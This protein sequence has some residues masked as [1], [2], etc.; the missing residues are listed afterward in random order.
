MKRISVLVLLVAML[1]PG[2]VGCTAENPQEKDGL[3]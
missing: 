2:L 1:L 3:R